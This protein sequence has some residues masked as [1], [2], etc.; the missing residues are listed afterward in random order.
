[1]AIRFR[2]IPRQD[3][4]KQPPPASLRDNFAVLGEC[5]QTVR[6]LQSSLPRVTPSFTYPS[7]QSS[8]RGTKLV[9]LSKTHAAFPSVQ[10]NAW[11]E[12]SDS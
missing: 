1:M 2:L 6:F 11:R 12:A 4:P 7:G 5:S 10:A 8:K 9:L 3:L